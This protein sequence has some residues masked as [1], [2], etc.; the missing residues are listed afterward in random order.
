MKKI[1]CLIVSVSFFMMSCKK[2]FIELAPISSVSVAALFKTDKDF[3]DAVIGS[4]S[5][6]RNQY[7]DFWM[8][9]DVASD[10]SWKEV[11]R[12]QSS[13]YIDVFT[14]DA[15]D[16]LLKT[17]WNN[18]YNLIARTNNILAKIE[19]A[20]A[21]VVTNK[22]RHIAE[23]KF[24]RAFAYFDLVRL[25]GDVPM[26]T[27]PID[28]TEAYKAGR[29]KVEK[30][31]S[32]IIIKDL[33]DAENGLPVKYTGTEIGRATKG[34]A[35]A[36]LG[37]VYLTI[38]DF[39]KAE[40]KFQEVTTLGY[41]LL[42][43][44]ND[45]FDYS[46]EEHHSEY[47]FDIEYAEALGGLGS[48]FT[49]RFSPLSAPFATFYKITGGGGE[50]N[51]PTMDL[52]KAFDPKDLR[53]DV[54]VDA[55]GGFVDGTGTFV[56]FLQASTVTK[57]YLTPV[58]SSGDSK[59]NWKVLRYADVLLMYAE[60]LNEN[61]KTAEAVTYVNQVRTRAG[62]AGYTGLSVADAR[63]KIYLERRLE[64][65]ME[66]HRWF[67]LVRTGRA[68][69]ILQAKGMKSFMTVF[70]I[71]LGQLQLMNNPAIFPQNTGYK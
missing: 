49:N 56:K 12:N 9:G 65:G 63:E 7:N 51:N 52:F 27:T 62:L 71:P 1:F 41:A 58:I 19:K 43:N 21:A 17:T 20:D 66:G 37:N 48:G 5:V 55:S 26:I 11:S 68:L 39:P 25:F 32:E 36:L 59:A 34:A 33:Q 42:K 67:D 10:D 15:N 69:A 29:E 24:L 16:A 22:A 47:I 54:T 2:D 38:K 8:F 30:I 3:Q 61:G 44:Y 53:R 18:Y 31:Y 28:I 6:L 23:A 50:D 35:K 4:Y 45:L 70:P 14:L 40:T 13:Y 64:L 57:K 60:A 46:K